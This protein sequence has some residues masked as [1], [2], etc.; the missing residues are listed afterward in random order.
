M[1]HLKR[2]VKR[3]VFLSNLVYT[4]KL[5]WSRLSNQELKSD[6]A[7]LTDFAL[8]INNEFRRNRF[9]NPLNNYGYKCFSQSDED[10]ITLEILRRIGI[11]DKGVFAEFGVGDGTENNTLILAAMGWRGFWVGGE[12]LAFDVRPPKQIGFAYIR[13]WVTKDNI[14]DHTKAGMKA[15]G[16]N[17]IDVVSLDL[18]GNDLYFVKEILSAGFRPRLFIVEYNAKFPPP[19]RF[20]IDYDEQHLWMSDDY[21]GASLMSFVDVFSQVDYS[22]VCC[23][24]HT[25]SNAFFVDS[26]FRVAFEDVPKSVEEIYVTPQPVLCH[27]NGS[28]TSLRTINN[29][30]NRS[31]TI[32][33]GDIDSNWK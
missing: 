20:A 14:V 28:P 26:T 3:S 5:I 23:N 16:A 9:Q 18:D 32:A 2:A 30:I 21:F 8:H 31:R 7:N 27:K 11:V 19:V 1:F 15:I 29:V 17:F 10:G 4:V 22:L 12:K 6:I 13:D 33:L 25:G 24:L